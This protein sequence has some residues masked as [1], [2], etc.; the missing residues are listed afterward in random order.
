MYCPRNSL[1]YIFSKHFHKSTELV[2]ITNFDFC[3]PYIISFLRLKNTNET[4]HAARNF[5][6]NAIR[7]ILYTNLIEYVV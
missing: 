6:R 4:K 7:I 2:D 3:K 1:Y 5:M